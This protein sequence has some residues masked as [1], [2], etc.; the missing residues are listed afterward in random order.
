[1][2]NISQLDDSY[3]DYSHPDVVAINA[4]FLEKHKKAGVYEV[5]GL[6]FTC[7]PCIYHPHELSSSRFAIRGLFAELPNLGQHILELGTG[8]GVVGICLAKHGLN[9]TLLDI[10]PVAVAC[11]ENNA[12]KNNVA[13]TVHQ[14]DLFAA[15]SE[16]K[17][18]AIFFNIPLM[19][20]PIEEPLEIISCDEGGE[21]LA[22]FLNEAPD[23][24]LPNG[25]V[26]V[27]LANIGNRAAMMQALAN[28][29][30]TIVHAEFYSITKAWRWLISARPL[31]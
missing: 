3:W 21:L 15:V 23:Y 28:Y 17:Y 27:S 2:Q 7:P 30:H 24:L 29:D 31:A 8:S 9:V 10:D 12:I 14:S 22:R 11:A 4:K 13:V 18:D 26:Y 6:T 1:M 5:S 20:K 25:Q 19:D 16:Q